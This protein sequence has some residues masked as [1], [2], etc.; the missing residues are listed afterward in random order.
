[1]STR[2][3]LTR[4][5][6]PSILI[7]SIPKGSIHDHH[8]HPRHCPPPPRPPRP[9]RPR[10][11]GL[12]RPCRDGQVAPPPRLHRPGAAHG[13]PRR[14][15]LQNVLHQLP[16][17][18]RPRLRRHLCRTRPRP[19]PPLHRPVRRPQPPRRN[20]RHHLR[21]VACGT[22]LSIVQE[23]IPAAI[24]TEFCYLGWQE[25]LSMLAQLVEPEIP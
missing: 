20:V 5:I 8:T 25:S 13:C 16:H 21:P 2:S 18:P 14:R 17:R 4:D 19:A 7:P 10:L 9:R 11:Q 15:R 3:G 1:M 12:H 22:E 24:P 6:A 23:G